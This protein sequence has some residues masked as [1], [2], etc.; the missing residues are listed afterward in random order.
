VVHATGSETFTWVL[1][2]WNVPD[3]SPAGE[4]QWYS[5]AWIGIDGNTDVTQIGTLQFVSADAGGNFNKSCYAFYE[6]WPNSW[7][8]ITNLPVSFGDLM[9]GL[10]CLESSTE[11]W[12]CLLNVT[13]GFIAR[14][15]FTAPTG[16][17]HW[18]IRPSGYSNGRA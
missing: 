2:Q 11:A 15:T 6:W 3:V 10:I 1:G 7:Q 13:N 16:T 8:A 18:K 9:L 14:F 4:G 17:V 5:I 12:F